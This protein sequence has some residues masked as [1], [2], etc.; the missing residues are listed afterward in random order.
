MEARG[1]DQTGLARLMKVS[2]STVSRWLDGAAPDPDQLATLASLLEVSTDNLLRPELDAQAA[3]SRATMPRA[4]ARKKEDD[5][6]LR[7]YEEILRPRLVEEARALLAAEVRRLVDR[8]E[9]KG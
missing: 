6:L 1:Y 4:S 9:K 7:K 2:D 5:G 3:T 8:W